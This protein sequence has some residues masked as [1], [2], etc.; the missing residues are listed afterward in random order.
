[1]ENSLGDG[2]RRVVGEP[3]GRSAVMQGRGEAALAGVGVPE[4]G[5]VDGFQTF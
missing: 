5:G 1:M 2:G 4:A 3:D